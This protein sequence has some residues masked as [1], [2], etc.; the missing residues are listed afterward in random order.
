MRVE[1]TFYEFKI[2]Y[3]Y[4]VLVEV[5]PQYFNSKKYGEIPRIEVNIFYKN[6]INRKRYERTVVF[7]CWS[8]FEEFIINQ[9]LPHVWSN[10]QK[11]QLSSATKRR[12]QS[13][14]EEIKKP[15]S[16]T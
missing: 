15:F 3:E 7:L 8:D 1:R 2:Y 14:I 12:I 16:H 4:T 11:R 9:F 6:Q 10:Y 5:E 13:Q